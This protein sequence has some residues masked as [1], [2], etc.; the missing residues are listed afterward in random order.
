MFLQSALYLVVVACTLQHDFSFPGNKSVSVQRHTKEPHVA[1]YLVGSSTETELQLV[2]NEDLNV[3]S[4][5]MA[6][7]IP[8][9]PVLSVSNLK[10]LK[11]SVIGNSSAKA[12]LAH[13]G[14]LIQT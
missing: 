2:L 1:V 13:N 12:E 9:A 10:S 4:S 3:T 6:I 5:R 11:N 7:L 8:P 14:A